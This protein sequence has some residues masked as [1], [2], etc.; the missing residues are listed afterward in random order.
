MKLVRV[1]YY[2]S[3][4]FSTAISRYLEKGESRRKRVPVIAVPEVAH[5]VCLRHLS[6]VLAP[7][8]G[9]DIAESLSRLSGLHDV[10]THT[11]RHCALAGKDSA[12][13]P[14]LYE[15]LNALEAAIALLR[16]SWSESP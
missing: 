1:V 6:R 7:A 4:Q 11:H 10:I 2:D 3:R 16:A 15:R 14:D 8:M 13:F 12:M 5:V 9:G